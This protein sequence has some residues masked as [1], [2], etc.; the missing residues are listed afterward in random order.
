MIDVRESLYHVKP[1]VTRLERNSSKHFKTE[2]IGT[3]KTQNANRV[4]VKPCHTHVGSVKA[5]NGQRDTFVLYPS[6]SMS[7][8]F[9]EFW[10]VV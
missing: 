10:I 6:D 3:F 4:Q 1:K 7:M 5:T 8:G 2:A 9:S